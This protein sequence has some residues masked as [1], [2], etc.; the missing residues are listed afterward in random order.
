MEAPTTPEGPNE[1]K[2]PYNDSQ[3]K[4]LFTFRRRPELPAKPK[5]MPD[6]IRLSKRE[7]AIE[8]H[9]HHTRKRERQSEDEI[10]TNQCNQV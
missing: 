2:K 7:D 9:M 10:P 1:E 3:V 8:S 5:A 4:L 6:K